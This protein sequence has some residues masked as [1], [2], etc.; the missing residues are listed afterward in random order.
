MPSHTAS[1]G[2]SPRGIGQIARA[3]FEWRRQ[4]SG[5]VTSTIATAGAFFRSAPE[6]AVPDL[7]LVFVVAL[8]DDHARKAPTWATVFPASGCA[9]PLQPWHGGHPKQQPARGAGRH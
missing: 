8:V 7:Q 1:F 6:V 4:R 9:A 5:M 2:A 3:M